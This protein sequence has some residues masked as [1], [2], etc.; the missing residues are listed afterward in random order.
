MLSCRRQQAAPRGP[1]GGVLV[2]ASAG[3]GEPGWCLGDPVGPQTVATLGTG[4]HGRALTQLLGVGAPFG[5]KGP[6]PRGHARAPAD[7]S[8]Q[9]AGPRGSRRLP[10]RPSPQP[11][12]AMAAGLVLFTP[13]EERPGQ[14]K[15]GG[16]AGPHTALRGPPRPPVPLVLHS[17]TGQG[18]PC[19]QRGQRAKPILEA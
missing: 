17:H 11:P 7:L 9:C 18:H 1:Q 2:D 15:W 16:G 10:T 13:G 5:T 4:A 19:P 6:G 12:P 14:A 8:W 3:V